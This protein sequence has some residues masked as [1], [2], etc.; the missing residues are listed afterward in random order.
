MLVMS[1]DSSSSHY[2]QYFSIPTMTLGT[3]W[4]AADCSVSNRQYYSSAS[5]DL[6]YVLYSYYLNTTSHLYLYCMRV[7]GASLRCTGWLGVRRG[8]SWD[9]YLLVAGRHYYVSWMNIKQP[10]LGRAS[11]ERTCSIYIGL[12]PSDRQSSRRIYIHTTVQ[13]QSSFCFQ[14][15][16][17]FNLLKV[18]DCP[19]A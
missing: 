8:G 1:I 15:C 7:K 18:E 13:Q 4:E 10:Q 12:Q 19:D 5:Q 6:H 17:S 3:Y 2:H 9:S 16:K 11:C 14:M